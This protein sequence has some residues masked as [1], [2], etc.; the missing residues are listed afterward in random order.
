MECPIF[1]AQVGQTYEVVGATS[2]HPGLRVGDKLLISE[3]A[4]KQYREN[5]TRRESV[6]LAYSD[7]CIWLVPSNPIGVKK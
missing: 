1:A 7:P 5:L 6:P 4:G 2:Q 3:Q